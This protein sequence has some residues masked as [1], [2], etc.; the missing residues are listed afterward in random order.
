[1]WRMDW[2]AGGGEAG[3]MVQQYLTELVGESL[4]TAVCYFF[5]TG[6]IRNMF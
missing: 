3:A 6:I 4:A 5:F 1:M 2:K